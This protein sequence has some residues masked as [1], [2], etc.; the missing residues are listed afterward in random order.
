MVFAPILQ[1]LFEDHFE[2]WLHGP[3]VR[4][5]YQARLQLAAYQYVSGVPLC[6][7]KVEAHIQEVLSLM[8]SSLLRTW[9]YMVPPENGLDW[10]PGGLAPLGAVYRVDNEDEDEV[11]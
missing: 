6:R 11:L 3:C 1:P 8:A 9:K 4:G 2:A 10:L 5:C 7:K